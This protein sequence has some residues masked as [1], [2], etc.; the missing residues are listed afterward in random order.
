MGYR[1]NMNK[2]FI[3]GDQAELT[4]VKVWLPFSWG[5]SYLASSGRGRW[6]SRMGDLMTNWSEMENRKG[7][8]AASGIPQEQK[9]SLFYGGYASCFGAHFTELMVL[10]TYLWWSLNHEKSEFAVGTL[11][12]IQPRCRESKRWEPPKKGFCWQP[13]ERTGLNVWWAINQVYCDWF[14]LIPTCWFAPLAESD[15]M[16]HHGSLREAVQELLY[17]FQAPTACSSSPQIVMT[18]SNMSSWGLHG[19][20]RFATSHVSDLAEV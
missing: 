12:L 18:T 10:N 9:R 14:W 15:P 8:T 6:S 4:Y 3:T 19:S 17:W 16:G 20:F 2:W 1:N 7:L 13:K 5:F 11:H